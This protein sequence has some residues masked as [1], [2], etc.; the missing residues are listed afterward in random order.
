M[1]SDR[2]LMCVVSPYELTLSLTNVILKNLFLT[3]LTLTALPLLCAL[4]VIQSTL[5]IHVNT[6]PRWFSACSRV[7]VCVWVVALHAPLCSHTYAKGC[8]N[9]CH[10]TSRNFLP[11]F[12]SLQIILHFIFLR[13][14]MCMCLYGIFVMWFLIVN[15]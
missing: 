3:F 14:R 10:F 9:H 2:E 13:S 11:I 1:W 7:H 6:V 15:I 4:F 8:V 12:L 5:C